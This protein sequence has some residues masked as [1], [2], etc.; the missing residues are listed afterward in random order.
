MG[1]I[2]EGCPE[3][4]RARGL[5]ATHY[6]K[7]RRTRGF[8]QLCEVAD[9]PNPLYAKGRCSKHYDTPNA[10]A[11]CCMRCAAPLARKPGKG[12]PPKLCPGC[13][14]QANRDR[15]KAKS[16]QRTLARRASAT[17]LVPDC[18]NKPD[19]PARYCP[20]H[21]ICDA[22]GCE[23]LK[24]DGRWC[25]VHR[26]RIRQDRLAGTIC[27]VDGCSDPQWYVT[28]GLCSLHG[29]RVGLTGEVGPATRRI[30]KPT[31]RVRERSGYVALTIDGRR[32]SEHRY[33]MEQ[34][35]GRELE[36]FENVHHRNGVRD[37]NRIENLE[38][39]AVPPRAGQRVT[40]LV[41]WVVQ[42]YP[43]VARQAL[44]GR[45]MRLF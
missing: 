29:R 45:E 14:V 39:W 40:D 41:R 11:G 8:G 38:L 2:I 26:K 19:S 37:D 42:H 35:L 33:V 15:S 34:A 44:D 25:P 32:I 27:V 31:G 17:C 18:D 13:R 6:S 7:E 5:C 24:A 43:E 23:N 36:R 10:W 22:D 12:G 30:A 16:K 4:A 28:T 21:R 1:C 3:D 20:E 9:C